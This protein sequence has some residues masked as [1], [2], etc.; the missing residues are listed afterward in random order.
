V[1]KIEDIY[2]EVVYP[3]SREII[4]NPEKYNPK[5]GAEI[6]EPDETTAIF[7]EVTKKENK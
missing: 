4:R 3:L 5:V 7:V 1:K 2:E 6:E